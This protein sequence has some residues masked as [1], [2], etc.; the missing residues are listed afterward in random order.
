MQFL[1]RK[2][3]HPDVAPGTGHGLDGYGNGRGIHDDARVLIRF[4]GSLPPSKTPADI[5]HVP[6]IFGFHI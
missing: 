1:G 2:A 6:Q 5:S 3:H 4:T